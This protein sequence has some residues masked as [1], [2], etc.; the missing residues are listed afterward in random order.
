MKILCLGLSHH[1]AALAV[2]E[3]LS[4]P[5]PALRAALARFSC[6]R[7]DRPVAVRELVILS[8]CN[9]LELYAAAPAADFAP[10]VALLAESSGRPPAEFDASLYRH[11]GDEAI[12]H[13][14]RVA[15]GLD[16]LVLGEPQIL[17]QVT[18]AYAAALGQGAAGPV[19]AAL[20]RSAIH[21]GKRA[22]T[23][24]AIARN[25]ASVSSMA[26]RLAEERVGDLA[27]AHI[28]VVGAGEMAELAVAALHKRGVAGLTV[29]NRTLERAAQ[30]ADRWGGRA[31]T[32]ERLAD[33]L[34]EADIIITSTGAPH[35]IIGPEVVA[36]ALAARPERPLVFVDIAVPRDVDPD[37]NQLPGAR[38]YDLDDLQAHLE[39]AVAEREREAPRA[40]AI[41]AEEAAAFGAWLERLEILPVISDLRA[42]AEAIRR[43][44]VER[45]LRHLDHLD[46]ADRERIEALASALVNKLLHDPTVRLK[47]EANNGH[48]TEYAAAVRYLFGLVPA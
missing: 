6:G 4:L 44:E 37:V 29:V 48:A 13:L 3:A 41:A 24:T 22:R 14:C 28:L 31:L 38:V 1:T 40:E 36:P 10:L 9:R 27:A 20:F 39:D 46:D 43:A 8:T 21:A 19:L 12:R 32:F 23:E 25:P 17:G 26:I 30:L 11:E 34:A 7:E 2:R 5:A 45:T 42:K 47:A 35:L 15:A 33:A 18:D 16:S